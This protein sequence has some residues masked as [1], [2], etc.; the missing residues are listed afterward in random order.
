MNMTK[1][2]ADVKATQ[3]NIRLVLNGG[4]LTVENATIPIQWFFTDDLIERRPTRVLLIEQ[5]QYEI[6]EDYGGCRGARIMYK[7]TDIVSFLQL[8]SPGKHRIAV[9]ALN[10]KP[11]KM[12][13]LD[14]YGNRCWKSN[15]FFTNIAEAIKSGDFTN[16]AG[17]DVVGA[18][19]VEIDVPEELFAPKP[20][21]WFGKKVRTWV[22]RWHKNPPRDECEYRGRLLFAFTTQP[23]L[24]VIGHVV[25]FALQVFMSIVVPMARITVLFLGFRP[26]PIFS[27][28]N[29]IWKDF[30][31]N[32]DEIEIF[33]RLGGKRYK[34]WVQYNKGRVIER[35][36]VTGLEITSL[37][38][39]F[40]W[41]EQ[42]YIAGAGVDFTGKAIAL[43]IMLMAVLA[44]SFFN[45]ELTPTE[46][47]QAQKDAETDHYAA[48]LPNLSTSHA[49][50]KVN[51]SKLPPAYQASAVQ[52]FRVAFWDIKMR[53][54]R[55]YSS[56]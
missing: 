36:P 19:I 45:K 56:R 39:T 44:L 17:A 38:L 32:G 47:K 5:D 48:W 11:S 49:P 10:D 6:E 29:Y 13:Y 42:G 35:M 46:I 24:F 7:I 30:D 37:L 4:D 50:A 25:K 18:T 2:E 22:N 55:P 40:W 28:F 41:L 23:I 51:L 33:S 16:V 34:V 26:A 52:R 53:I 21:T 43:V 3:G 54:C 1:N 15:I 20:Q 9:L 14:A 27:G 12:E 31:L 8:F